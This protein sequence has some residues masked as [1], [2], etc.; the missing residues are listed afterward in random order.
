MNTL[1]FI[2]PNLDGG[3]FGYSTSS[4]KTPVVYFSDIKR[5]IYAFVPKCN[6]ETFMPLLSS[7]LT[8]DARHHGVVNGV[9]EIF[10]VN[11]TFVKSTSGLLS[12][13]DIDKFDDVLHVCKLFIFKTT[14][15]T[16][17]YSLRKHLYSMQHCYP[18]F[19]V[20]IPDTLE[21]RFLFEKIFES[22]DNL[23]TKEDGMCITTLSPTVKL[24]KTNLDELYTPTG[25]F[26][27]YL[28]GTVV[29]RFNHISRQGQA[30]TQLGNIPIVFINVIR[31]MNLEHFHPEDEAQLITVGI[32]F[33]S[34]EPQL[35]FYM[36]FMVVED[37]DF[38]ERKID[39]SIYY[40]F[41]NEKQMLE[42][43]TSF[44]VSGEYAAELSS[45]SLHFLLG[46]DLQKKIVIYLIE[47]MFYKDVG[48]ILSYMCENSNVFMF[49]KFEILIETTHAQLNEFNEICYEDFCNHV[50]TPPTIGKKIIKK[51][52]MFKPKF[53]GKYRHI[54]EGCVIEC[55]TRMDQSKLVEKHIAKI[56]EHVNHRYY[57]ET[58][59][60]EAALLKLSLPTA[61]TAS[62]FLKSKLMV[63]LSIMIEYGVFIMKPL[64][65]SC[66]I[67]LTDDVAIERV[68]IE[69]K[70][71][72]VFSRPGVYFKA[73]HLD[74]DSFYPSIVAGFRLDY[75]TVDVVKKSDLNT[76][77]SHHPWLDGVLDVYELDDCNSLL[78]L[79]DFTVLKEIGKIGL[80][81]MFEKILNERRATNKP[82]WNRLLKVNSNAMLGCLAEESFKYSS[83]ALYSAI[84]FLGRKI[85]K[86][87]ACNIH[88]FEIDVDVM[89]LRGLF[90][91]FNCESTLLSN[92]IINV[93]TDGFTFTN[94]INVDGTII[95]INRFFE[96]LLGNDYIRISASFKDATVVDYKKSIFYYRGSKKKTWHGPK[97]NESL[98]L[99]LDVCVETKSISNLS[100][101]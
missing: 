71:G 15:D 24:G 85:I 44:F 92:N 88:L 23:T 18:R 46:K 28:S 4:K 34:T 54:E 11:E 69:N 96:S 10:V 95:N 82:V 74:F 73:S 5:A 93:N 64:G 48:L 97:M 79:K 35:I 17:H 61:S 37:V 62:T 80:F 101:K 43:F 91:G 90:N 19:F 8:L 33:N 49:S 70:G 2:Q 78:I 3:K 45:G 6:V 52:L 20:Y 76:I 63:F 40:K 41:K 47:R 75:S 22:T 56:F 77:Y 26:N 12:F 29:N 59:Y 94:P 81:N 89:A 84:T 68:K 42:K 36:H 72:F 16:A 53:I 99:T 9:V 21:M 32:C 60:K 14:D 38:K 51:E 67:N 87:L 57:I 27:T 1:L 39:N 65:Q 100:I 30:V 55:I 66:A 31:L 50:I 7:H 58:L 86:F 25:C 13:L 98:G 83:H